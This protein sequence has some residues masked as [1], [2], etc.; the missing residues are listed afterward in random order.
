MYIASRMQF[1]PQILQVSTTCGDGICGSE[2]ENHAR[3]PHLQK[4]Q[5][6]L[7][8][9]VQSMEHKTLSVPLPHLENENIL[10]IGRETW[11][12]VQA[13]TTNPVTTNPS[14]TEPAMTSPTKH[15]PQSQKFPRTQNKCP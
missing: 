3:H 2:S 15:Q 7:G 10:R 5:G 13:L 14:T 8:N 1:P 12:Q 6:I 4:R 11:S 9:Q